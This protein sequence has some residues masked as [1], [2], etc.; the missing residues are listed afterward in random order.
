MCLTQA[1]ICEAAALCEPVNAPAQPSGAAAV[2]A[3]STQAQ[4][5]V[6]VTAK[7]LCSGSLIQAQASQ[8]MNEACLHETM[9]A[10]SALSVHL[11]SG[12]GPLNCPA[13]LSTWNLLT[14]ARYRLPPSLW[15]QNTAYPMS[16]VCSGS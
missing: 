11:S 4:R 7:M 8:A 13:Q 6:G 14:A 10:V 16:C 5:P 1:G 12:Q 15:P 9:N 2:Q 3:G